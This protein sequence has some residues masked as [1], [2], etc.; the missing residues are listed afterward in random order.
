MSW[1]FVDQ[2]I[3]YLEE[4]SRCTP[5]G[6][7]RL[8][9]E[10]RHKH[11]QG[12]PMDSVFEPLRSPVQHI[13]QPRDVFAIPDDNTFF[14]DLFGGP[15]LSA[16]E[17]R[18]RYFDVLVHKHD[19]GGGGNDEQQRRDLV[20]LVVDAHSHACRALMHLSRT[21]QSSSTYRL[22]SVWLAQTELEGWATGTGTGM[23]VP[24]HELLLLSLMTFADCRGAEIRTDG[25]PDHP[26][27]AF[28]CALLGFMTT[29]G[30]LVRPPIESLIHSQQ[31]LSAVCRQIS[32]IMR[33]QRSTLVGERTAD[34]SQSRAASR[35]PCAP[36]RKK[37]RRCDPVPAS[38]WPPGSSG[39]DPQTAWPATHG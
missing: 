33:T 3:R 26:L 14:V 28:L 36:H 37:S 20:W 17:L 1:F 34:C 32:T 39:S 5:E 27:T 12:M 31:V 2:S 6:L 30:V 19:G 35:P 18:N 21:A 4:A 7:R 22:H 11:L 10:S 8:T 29:E 9:H 13:S 23:A 16:D 15:V 38:P 25:V 24:L